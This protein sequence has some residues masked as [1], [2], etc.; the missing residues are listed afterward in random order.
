MDLLRCDFR[1]KLVG[2]QSTLSRVISVSLQEDN[3]PDSDEADC[4]TPGP[5]V[6]WRTALPCGIGA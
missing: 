3:L 6:C 5:F 2:G 1:V 4:Q